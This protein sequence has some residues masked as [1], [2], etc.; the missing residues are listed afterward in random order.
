MLQ[1]CN[2]FN[3]HVAKH[4]RIVN[5]TVHGFLYASTFAGS[6]L[7]INNSQHVTWW[8]SRVGL[9]THSSLSTNLLT[10]IFHLPCNK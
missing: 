6:L 10:R 9:H 3:C 5:T 2:S 1:M 7:R 8:F 4:C